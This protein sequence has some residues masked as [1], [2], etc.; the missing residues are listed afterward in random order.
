MRSLAA[1]VPVLAVLSSSC[2]REEPRAEAP[3]VEEKSDAEILRERVRVN[4]RDDEA[5]HQLAEMYD[6][7]ALYEEEIEALKAL[8]AAR[9]DLGYAY[10]RMGTAYNRLA[11]YE[12]AVA[13]FALAAK[14]RHNQPMTFNNMAFAYGKLGK[15]REEVAALQKAVALRPTYAIARFNLALALQKQ[16]KHAEALKEQARLRDVDESLAAAL[17]QELDARRKGDAAG[18]GPSA[19]R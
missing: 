5:W 15:T 1:I 11:R 8:V 14:Y 13:S 6:R 18:S 12:D 4:P 3:A 9:P 10:F 19:A 7:A 17:L 2:S 16:G